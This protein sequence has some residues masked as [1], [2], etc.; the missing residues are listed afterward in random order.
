MTHASNHMP[1]FLVEISLWKFFSEK[2]EFMKMPQTE[3][4]ANLGPVS[5][6]D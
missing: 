2:D 1:Q 6:Y 4:V 5:K 3:K